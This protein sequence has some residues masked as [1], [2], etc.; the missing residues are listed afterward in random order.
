MSVPTWFLHDLWLKHML[1]T[2][3]SFLGFF[4]FVIFHIIHFWHS[5]H[6]Q[7]LQDICPYSHSLM[8]FL[9]LN[10][11]Q[12]TS[13]QN[14]NNKIM[15]ILYWVVIPEHEACPEVWLLNI[16][17]R[18]WWKLIF[19]LTAAASNSLLVRKHYV[20]ISFLGAAYFAGVNLCRFHL[21]CHIFCE[22]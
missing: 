19:T 4:F 18:H 1:S 8:F 12:K 6:Y 14:P 9:Y 2:T 15:S 11:H 16:V 7:W 20:P 13:K 22:F 3:R 17:S 5:F 21:Q 10:K